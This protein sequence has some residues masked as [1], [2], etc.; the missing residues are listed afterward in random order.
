MAGGP[1]V[2][3]GRQLRSLSGILSCVGLLLWASGPAKAQDAVSPCS[4]MDKPS[5][6][7]S[8]RA[9]GAGCQRPLE[10][11]KMIKIMKRDSARAVARKGV[12]QAVL[13]GGGMVP[14][15]IG[16]FCGK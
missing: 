13:E 16:T 11:F 5:D 14:G 12:V 10:R 3:L 1:F 9:S 4:R 2:S 8:V 15:H 6:W 7:R